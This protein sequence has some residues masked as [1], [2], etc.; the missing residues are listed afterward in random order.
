MEEMKGLKDALQFIAELGVQA[1]TPQVVE[2]HGKTYC[3]DYLVEYGALPKAEPLKLHT[4]TSLIE[5]IKKCRTEFNNDHDQ[6][7]LHVTAPD[8][9]YFFSSLNYE[10]DR[11][12]LAICEAILPAFRYDYFMEQ[13]RFLIALQ[14]AFETTA[15]KTLIAQFASNVIQESAA[16]YSDDGITQTAVI[17]TGVAKKEVAL[18]PSPAKL[19]PY[20][21]FLEC[22]QPESAFLFRMRDV[23]EGKPAFSLIEADGGKWKADAMQNVVNYI[24]QAIPDLIENGEIVI[25]A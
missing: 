13:E 20:R 16:E 17:K 25:L 21:T 18:V 23:K 15:D 9:I 1:K 12:T 3:R 19:K 2:V 4:L 8:K 14:A 7:I 11:E 22:D 5:Y 24:R 6:M 10:R